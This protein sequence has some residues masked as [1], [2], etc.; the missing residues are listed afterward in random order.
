MIDIKEEIRIRLRYWRQERGLSQIDLGLQAK[1][2]RHHIQLHE[3]GLVVLQPEEVERIASV[4]GLAIT[5]SIAVIA[6]E[7]IVASQVSVLT[8]RELF[9]AMAMQGLLSDC[10]T[11]SYDEIN[12][13]KVAQAAAR[14][15]RALASELKI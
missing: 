2:P 8:K 10:G 12:M 3:R 4:L 7:K 6:E 14:A 5:E 11:H 13:F 1:V 15:A 9:A